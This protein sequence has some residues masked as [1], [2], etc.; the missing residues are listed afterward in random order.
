MTKRKKARGMGKV[1]SADLRA[2][3]N[4]QK[5]TPLARA[6]DE[7]KRAAAKRRREEAEGRR[8]SNELYYTQ[9]KASQLLLWGLPVEERLPAECLEDFRREIEVG[10]DERAHGQWRMVCREREFLALTAKLKREIFFG[11]QPGEPVRQGVGDDAGS[12]RDHPEGPGRR[13]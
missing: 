13:P 10:V 12:W 1:V 11:D 7:A 6:L 9:Q 8:H 2:A 4:W 3:R 5:P